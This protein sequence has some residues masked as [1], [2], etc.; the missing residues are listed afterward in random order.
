MSSQFNPY[1][2]WLGIPPEEQPPNH[3]RLLGLA[4]LE[5]DP[6][7]IRDAAERQIAHVRR[8]ALGEHS[9]LSQKI[10]NELAGAESCLL[11]PN[12]KA[13]YDAQLT[14]QGRPTP[15][16]T[17][18][19]RPEP[20]EN[21]PAPPKLPAAPPELPA[22][23]Y[24]LAEPVAKAAPDV[25]IGYGPLV[26][27]PLHVQA[28]AVP[29]RTLSTPQLKLAL[30]AVAVVVG[31]VIIVT[32]A[33]LAG[34]SSDDGMLSDSDEAP[35][36]AGTAASAETAVREGTE[37]EQ[38]SAS[39][40][41]ADSPSPDA[42]AAAQGAEV[43]LESTPSQGQSPPATDATAA[44]S[45]NGKPSTQSP[46]QPPPAAP[47]VPS[48]MPPASGSHVEPRQPA[49]ASTAPGAGPTAN[50]NPFFPG[51][52]PAGPTAPP[53][54]PPTHGGQ[55][56]GLPSSGIPMQPAY[57]AA[58]VT[59]SPQYSIA[60]PSGDV[61]TSAA[62]DLTETVK[63]ATKE[64]YYGLQR[65][66]GSIGY[67]LHDN[68]SVEVLFR[69]KGHV[70]RGNL[71][72]PV[73]GFFPSNTPWVSQAVPTLPQ[74]W[75]Q[76]KTSY[77]GEFSEGDPSGLAAIWDETG[78]M[79]FRGEFD[80]R[81]RNGLCCYF[82][83]GSPR[84][85]LKGRGPVVNQVYLISNGKVAETFNNHKLAEADDEAGPVLEALSA[86]EFEMKKHQGALRKRV[87][88][89][90]DK[91]QRGQLMFLGP[92]RRDAIQERDSGRRSQSRSNMEAAARESLRP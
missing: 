3:Y 50:V 7:V 67:A 59:S 57:P 35:K 47:F 23:E 15:Q 72:G 44:G 88:K 63:S 2:R 60:L 65:G 49:Q 78:Q 56:S 1:H 82:E 25:D 69:V 6:E 42:L 84:M 81:G 79:R 90:A 87:E 31:L 19:T 37:S 77:Y 33:V 64:M 24:A 32:L 76:T 85:V 36:S 68:G 75:N 29:G 66:D 5:D 20:H 9:D 86:A 41:P 48:G 17:V 61:L 52:T 16:S 21:A 18:R 34:R 40:P 12:K 38:D 8:Y 91:V 83:E 53:F 73:I 14:S 26:E 58:S 22:D 28:P 70:A 4:W 55:P 46:A 11:D 80:R 43:L 71:H 10:L 92:R 62:L 89:V 39:P 13:Q 54:F 45:T 27:Q 74:F 30:I 51:A